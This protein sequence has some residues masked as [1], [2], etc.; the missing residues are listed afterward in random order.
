MEKS[1]SLIIKKKKNPWIQ[2]LTLLSY[3]MWRKDEVRG[4]KQ[5]PRRYKLATREMSVITI[6]LDVLWFIKDL[7]CISVLVRDARTELIKYGT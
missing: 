3:L 7:T 6:D 2:P 5:T 4:Q 1:L